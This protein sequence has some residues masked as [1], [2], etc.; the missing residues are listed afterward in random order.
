MSQNSKKDIEAIDWD[1]GNIDKMPV[2]EQ[3]RIAKVFEQEFIKLK[4]TLAGSRRL[5]RAFCGNAGDYK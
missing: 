1:E 5:A 3:E 2:K 4:K